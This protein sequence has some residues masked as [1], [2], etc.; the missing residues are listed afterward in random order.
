MTVP[1]MNASN[2]HGFLKTGSLSG[3]LSGGGAVNGGL[4]VPKV[5][6]VI[7][8]DY[9]SLINKPKINGVEL[10]GDKSFP[11]LGLESLSNIEIENL[12]NS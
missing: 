12:L 4:N 9:N 5:I 10:I 1:K 8:K 3:S 7:D 6:T 11:D 2:L